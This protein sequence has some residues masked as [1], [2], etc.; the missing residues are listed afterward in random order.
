MEQ[1]YIEIDLIE[2]TAEFLVNYGFLAPEV[3][4]ILG[5]GLGKL[6]DYIEIDKAMS[7]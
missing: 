7:A 1:N 4:I 2:E 5:T 6:A 3:G